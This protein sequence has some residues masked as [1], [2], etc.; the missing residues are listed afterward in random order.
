MPMKKAVM[1]RF[2]LILL[3][4]CLLAIVDLSAQTAL[5]KVVSSKNLNVRSAPD[6][7]AEV[8]GVLKPEEIVQVISAYDGWAEFMFFGRHG[9]SSLNYLQKVEDDI[10][11]P[12]REDRIVK[13]V[14]EVIS[15]SSLNVR[16]SPSTQSPVIGSLASGTIIEVGE[17]VEGWLKFNHNGMEAYSSLKYLRRIE[18]VEQLAQDVEDEE[19]VVANESNAYVEPEEITVHESKSILEYDSLFE[20]TCF[21]SDLFDVYLTG[22]LGLGLSSY[23]W[24]DGEVNGKLGMSFDAVGQIY[25]KDFANLYMD[26]SIGYAYKGA[27][28]LPLHYLNIGL[29]PLGYYYDYKDFRFVG[30]VGLYL[31]IPLS[32]LRHVETSKFDFGIS[33]E[34]SAEYNLF[35]L[36]VEFNY[37][38]INVAVPYVHLHNWGVM[39][40]LGCKILSFN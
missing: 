33:V 16:S 12:V 27:A 39:A 36:G 28:K 34:L 18:I 23:T 11:R 6:T 24:S 19:P 20:K 38:F 35:S 10:V 13:V 37:G 1:K 2:L 15:S 4:I 25:W 31:G 8:I 22:H 32:S 5:Y 9:Y 40:K 14:Y 21:S 7:Q 30:N 29:T 26:A 17:E 3:P